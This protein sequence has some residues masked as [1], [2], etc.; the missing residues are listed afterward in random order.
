MFHKQHRRVI[1][2]L[3]AKKQAQKK[4]NKSKTPSPKKE[5]GVK[6]RAD[7]VS[8]KPNGRVEIQ[9]D[10]KTMNNILHPDKPKTMEELG[11]KKASE[12]TEVDNLKFEIGK[13]RTH[14]VT[15]DTMVEYED[16]LYL[17]QVDPLNRM[18]KF[19]NKVD[20]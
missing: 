8:R 11:M 6:L 15:W 3:A 13:L 20:D 12:I 7:M 18:V 10:R 19:L 16:N 4:V 14:F 2:T 1:A 17:V 5:G 9:V